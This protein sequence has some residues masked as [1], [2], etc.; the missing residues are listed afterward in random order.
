MNAAGS[1][2]HVGSPQCEQ[3]CVNGR[4]EESV[5]DKRSGSLVVATI[6]LLGV[7]ACFVRLAH[8][9]GW[10]VASFNRSLGAI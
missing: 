8:G 4:P 3:G 2:V 9:S 5:E 6:A 10:S 1:S 7:G